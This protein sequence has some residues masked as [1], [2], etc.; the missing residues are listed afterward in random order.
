MTLVQFRR[1]AKPLAVA[2]AFFGLGALAKQAYI[3]LGW[4]MTVGYLIAPVCLTLSY[5]LED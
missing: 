5:Y 3:T 4:P 1:V 2:F